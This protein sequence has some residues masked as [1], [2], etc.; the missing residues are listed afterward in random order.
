M[1]G[2]FKSKSV[3]ERT[4]EKITDLENQIRIRSSINE[5]VRKSCNSK[6]DWESVRFH[7]YEVRAMKRAVVS[8]RKTL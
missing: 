7:E 2:L 6:N 1:F 3:R 8:L 5:D 4:V